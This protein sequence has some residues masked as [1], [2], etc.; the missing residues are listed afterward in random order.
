M[1]FFGLAISQLIVF[2]V[3]NLCALVDG[4]L[5]I[6]A[7]KVGF[8]DIFLQAWGGSV[9]D[10][11]TGGFRGYPMAWLSIST[12]EDIDTPE[13]FIKSNAFT[14]SLQWKK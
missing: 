4:C 1:K 7:V 3:Y 10:D 6:H 8:V 12:A 2:R 11:A 14:L 5:I 9:M 13:A